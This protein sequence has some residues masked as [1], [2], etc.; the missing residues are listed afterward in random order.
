MI[1]SAQMQQIAAIVGGILLVFSGWILYRAGLRV[2]GGL[3][4]LLIALLL[5]FL[6]LHTP[7]VHNDPR[8]EPIRGYIYLGA[9]AV[10]GLVGA[11]VVIKVYYVLVAI[12][13]GLLGLVWQQGTW[14]QTW[15]EGLHSR[16]WESLLTGVSGAL[17][18]AVVFA[19]LGVLLHRY[20]V[21]L[22]T[23]TSGSIVILSHL[24]TRFQHPLIVPLLTVLGALFQLRIIRRRKKS[25]E[26]MKSD[27]AGQRR[28]NE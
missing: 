17:L 13:F 25:R 27:R 21:I 10:G 14:F 26:N 22:L 1:D 6:V 11:L 24:P 4:G 16:S 8:I 15:V 2:L 28:K 9:A 20:L 7:F 23:A 5:V 12:A 19:L 18:C 3:M